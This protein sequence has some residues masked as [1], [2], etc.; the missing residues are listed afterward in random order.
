MGLLLLE[1]GDEWG[2][3]CLFYAAY[4]AVKAALLEDTVFDTIDACQAVNRD[5]LPQDRDTTRHNGRRRTSSGREWGIN[6]LVLLLYRPAAGTYEKLHQA[7]IDVRYGDGL[8]ASI[9]DVRELWRRFEALRSEGAL[10][11]GRS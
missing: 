10:T 11:S 1:A 3:V 2:A 4:H 6:E 5:L 8:R 7:S 9:T